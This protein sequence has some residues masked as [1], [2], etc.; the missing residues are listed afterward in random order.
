M[1]PV[2]VL[3]AVLLLVAGVAACGGGDEELGQ[4]VADEDRVEVHDR[5]DW[6]SDLDRRCAEL[7]EE[8]A[9]LAVADPQD[10]AGAVAHAER[11]EELSGE[12]VALLDS[13]GVPDRDRE[14]ARRLVRHFD[15]LDAAAADLAEAA[16]AGDA[17]AVTSAVERLEDVGAAINP[18]AD[19]LDV[20]A[21][22]G[23]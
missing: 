19:G 7:N 23:F 16:R 9:D 22:G 15:D 13:A 11:V 17:E 8:Y 21:C 3:V 20:P 6:T 18:A 4:P 12:M 1:V 2:L 14:A 5:D 10:R